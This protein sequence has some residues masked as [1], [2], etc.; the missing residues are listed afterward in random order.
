MAQSTRWERGLILLLLLV[1]SLQS[2]HAV[3]IGVNRASLSFEEVL[4]GGYAET[5]IVVTTDAA[6]PIGG[7]VLLTGEAAE[8]LNFSSREFNFSSTQPY[9]LKVIVQPPSDAQLQTYNVDLVVI[10]GTI[11][12]S[13]GGNM[14]TSTR[15]S[16]RVPVQIRV[17][18][19]ERIECTVGGVSVL[20]TERGQPLEV[21]LS[22]QNRGNV[23]INPEVTI[24]VHDQLQAKSLGIKSAEFGRRILPTV[25]D[26]A[27]RSF[28]FDLAPSQYWATVKVPM[29]G[30]STL[31][32]FDVLEPG[33]IKDDGDFIRIEAPAWANTGDIVPIQ[34]IFRNKGT[35]GVRASFRGTISNVA[36]DEIVKVISTDEYVVEPGATAE[37]PTFF[38]PVVGGQYTVSGKVFYNNKLTIERNTI[39]NVNGAAVSQAG[40]SRTWAILIVLTI[41]ILIMLILIQRRKRRR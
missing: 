28:L 39:I 29:C 18:G 17:S 33:G 16:F 32:T 6:E 38:N 8:W 12:R 40:S 41:A 21:Q 10:T 27:S 15:A 3:A 20:D 25:T 13:E 2:A 11:A 14:G 23:R 35:R 31:Q 30:Y 5:T 9:E 22:I 26:E 4:R 24:E 19:T 1:C 34:A 36:T 7:E 37:I